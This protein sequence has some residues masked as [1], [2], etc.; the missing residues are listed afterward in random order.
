LLSS[1]G[2][3]LFALLGFMGVGNDPKRYK[4]AEYLV[5]EER[6]KCNN[7]IDADPDNPQDIP[8]LLPH[9]RGVHMPAIFARAQLR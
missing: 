7:A 3:Y 5:L 2:K 4:R 6:A 9:W 1:I 8:S